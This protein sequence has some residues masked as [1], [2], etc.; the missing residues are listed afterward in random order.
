M[1]VYSIKRNSSRLLDLEQC[2]SYSNWKIASW[3]FLL[4]KKCVD[5]SCTGADVLMCQVVGCL[6]TL[7]HL[8]LVFKVLLY[9]LGCTLRWLFCW[10]PTLNISVFE[11]CAASLKTCCTNNTSLWFGRCRRV[12]GIVLSSLVKGSCGRTSLASL[13]KY[14]FVM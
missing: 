5:S 8:D 6:C 4:K 2:F 1:C 12:A 3:I 13:V 10:W 7:A 11:S 14:V 9:L